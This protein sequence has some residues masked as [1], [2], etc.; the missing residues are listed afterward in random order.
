MEVSVS[1]L[2]SVLVYENARAS[3]PTTTGA[4]LTSL[5][6]LGGFDVQLSRLY[7]QLKFVI[8]D[9]GPALKQ[10]E[11]IVWPQENPAALAEG[12]VK[13]VQHDFFEPNPVRGAEV[14]WLR[15]ILFVPLSSLPP[16]SQSTPR[17][18]L[19]PPAG[20]TGPTTT[21]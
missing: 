5:T 19:P 4:L 9:R 8:Q 16:S 21:A 11:S 6:S 10:A 18:K 13:F 7:P 2:L 1:R 14:Y 3:A 12:R 20:T 17:A 15:S